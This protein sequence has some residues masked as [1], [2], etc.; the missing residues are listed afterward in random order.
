MDD[1]CLTRCRPSA[2]QEEADCGLSMRLL[3]IGGEGRGVASVARRSCDGVPH[4]ITRTRLVAGTNAAA[5]PGTTVGR[6]GDTLLIQCGD[7]PLAVVPAGQC[8]KREER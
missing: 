2:Q 1:A 5:A 8:P 3:A 7:G 4:R 6:D